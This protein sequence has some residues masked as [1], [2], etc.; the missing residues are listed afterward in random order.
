LGL[1]VLVWVLRGIGLLTFLPG[2]ILWFLI[3]ATFVLT[4]VNGLLE[5]R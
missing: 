3:L 4:V 5:T 2:S 1:T